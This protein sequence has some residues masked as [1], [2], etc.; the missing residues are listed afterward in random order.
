MPQYSGGLIKM[1]TES[2]FYGLAKDS[3][4]IVLEIVLHARSELIEL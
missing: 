2:K 4:E 3:V 1:V